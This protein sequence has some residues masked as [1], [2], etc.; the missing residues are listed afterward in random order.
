V[1]VRLSV[2]AS[3]STDAELLA[4]IE[5]A[6]S[7]HAGADAK[8]DQ[9]DLKRA[10]GLRS[11][12]LALR[13]MAGFDLDR[14]GVVSKEEFLAGVRALVLGSDRDKL[15]FA[16]RLHDHD[17]DGFLDREE[18]FRMIAI[19]LAESDVAERA[20]QPPEQLVAALLASADTNKDGR[21][22]FDEF[23]AAVRKRPHLLLQM[24]RSEA[25]WI[26]V[27]EDLLLRID[28]RAKRSG[29]V[30]R[31]ISN[32]GA[33][34]AFVTLWI[35]ANAG[36]LAY[37]LYFGR[38]QETTDPAMEAGRALGACLDLNGALILLPM[39][40]R[41]LTWVRSTWLG[42]VLPVDDAITFHKMVGHALFAFA[43]AHSTAFVLAYAEGHA[44]A[45]APWRVFTTSRG[46]TGGLLL[47]VFV[48][49]WIFSL[50]I[51]RRANRFELFY[52][53]HL[54]YVA[55]LALAIA[56]APRF[57]V[58]AGV[59]VA[60][61]LVEQIFR[62][63]RR[64][65]PSRVVS[66]L[67]LRSGVTRI[68]VERPPGLTFG[69]GDYVFLRLPA[70][71]RHEWHPFTISSAPEQP[72]LTFHLRSLG[73][74]TG[75]LRRRVEERSGHDL[76][77]YIDGPYGSPSAHIFASRFAVLIGAGIGVTPFA[78]VLESI[79]LRGNDARDAR[80]S[81]LEKVHFFWLNRD[82][83]S[84]EWFRGLLSRLEEIDTRG[85][86]DIHLC[87]TSARTGVTAL[88]L[89]L[90]R[91]LMHASGRSDIITGLRTK[92]HMGPPDWESMLRAIAERHAPARVDVFFCG[93]PGLSKSLAPLCRRLGMGFRE[94]RF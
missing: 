65:P 37:S 28:E 39:M 49:M 81:S 62:W 54:L 3:S 72:T 91:E 34:V 74:W 60:G 23:E 78:S 84:F 16:F 19:S 70:I 31:F 14:D 30:S 63:L 25:I 85:L 51:V 17:G 9:A 88:G 41:T 6:F 32:H 64:R 7:H 75:A 50:G 90:A 40:R 56:H 93:P 71:A 47:G 26:A 11:D 48:V 12:Y 43:V 29:A 2:R 44:S 55:W 1:E 82:Q 35:L 52:F 57:L 36:V 27:N 33:N 92:T 13:V 10:L 45:A 15:A 38:A 22:S 8:I 69:A 24:T 59:P 80:P 42:R 76:A 68:E 89:E 86:L 67:A 94:E 20:T 77:A 58:F 66:A 5:R 79:V 87:M 46:L 83:Y 18:L 61:F 4:T 73:N 53:T 21:L